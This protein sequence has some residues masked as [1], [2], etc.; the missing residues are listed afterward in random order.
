NGKVMDG[1][2]IQITSLVMNNF[3]S[4]RYQGN[5]NQH[6]SAENKEGG[7]GGGTG[8]V[9]IMNLYVK[10]LDPTVDN[11]DLFNLFRKFGRIVS[12]RV[13]SN[14]Q[15]GL[16]KG[17]GFVS[18]GK[19]EEAAL[20]LQEM[21]GYQFRTKPMIIAYHE[22][23]KPR[24]EKSSSTT[25]SSF[26]SPPPSAP[27]DYATTPYFETRHPH[28]SSMNTLGIDHVEH[29]AIN[30][31][32]LSVGAPMQRKLSVVENT[33]N[34]PPI[35]SSPP[36]ASR[37]SLASLASGASIQ[38]VPSHLYK[39][40]EEEKIEEESIRT[41]RRKGSLES[42]NSIMTESSAQVQRQ[43]MTEAVKQ[44]G[45]YGRELHDIVDMLLTLKR[46]ERSLCLFNSDFL[47]DKINAAAEA[48][49]IC[50]EDEGEQ[51]II[52]TTEKKRDYKV[53]EI[54]PRVFVPK[55][56]TVSP[57]TSPP[58]KKSITPP[59][60]YQHTED[61]VIVPPR[62]SKAIPIVA[63]PSVDSSKAAEIKAL[64]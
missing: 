5:N 10:N 15:N 62:K 59:M 45:S 8:Y 49:E 58:K 4:G 36:F 47:K 22:P 24:Q 31:K 17:Y 28:E 34:P 51:E 25:T 32:D 18:F 20:A 2:V 52:L 13:M 7:M 60:S 38:P 16:S 12:A 55:G 14:P 46:K 48:L 11:T 42:V 9:D 57:P 53:A 64:L 43:R 3:V 61:I 50:E 27:I 26:H 54:K 6:A 37:P 44:C 1:N 21:N 35:R 19:P 40:R 56:A 63:P 33:F 41:L 39:K 29:L 30:M 23:K